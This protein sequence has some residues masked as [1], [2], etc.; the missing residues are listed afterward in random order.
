M[1]GIPPPPVV[2]PFL[3]AFMLGLTFDCLAR[4]HDFVPL[5]VGR[6]IKVSHAQADFLADEDDPLFC[7]DAAAALSAAVL[8]W[9]LIFPS[10][11]LSVVSFACCFCCCCCVF[12]QFHFIFYSSFCSFRFI[13]FAF[14]VLTL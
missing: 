2:F 8:C 4:T 9:I 3:D 13:L 7:L 5:V 12:T 6:R 11:L 14:V 10:Y 1:C